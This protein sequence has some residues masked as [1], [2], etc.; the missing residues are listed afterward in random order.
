M[1][2]LLS[3]YTE[4][5]PAMYASIYYQEA[6]LERVRVLM[7]TGA[8]KTILSHAFCIKH[9]LIPLPD[10]EEETKTPV[11]MIRVEVYEN[12]RIVLHGDNGVDYSKFFPQIGS[13]VGQEYYFPAVI[14]MDVFSLGKFTLWGDKKRHTLILP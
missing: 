3:Q 7:D 14:G 10:I 13:P 12:I 9:K 8:N 2:I 5:R 11:G 4:V 1:P 6:L